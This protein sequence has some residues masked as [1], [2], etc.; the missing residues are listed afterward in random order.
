MVL[1]TQV[2]SEG[3]NT[4]IKQCK[5]ILFEKNNLII[6]F[7]NLNKSG[8]Y[9]ISASLTSDEDYMTSFFCIDKTKDNSKSY[10]CMG[11]DDAGRLWVKPYKRGFKVKFGNIRLDTEYRD[12]N[13]EMIS[14]EIPS[15]TS[16]YIYG[17]CI[18]KT[19]WINTKYTDG[20]E[21]T[22]EYFDSGK[23]NQ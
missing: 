13:D 2:F 1:S 4:S 3:K 15:E 14:K 8:N 20:I 16:D 5:Y 9:L 23:L 10:T 6:N 21:D 19:G 12:D 22:K 18:P 11:D 7:T 17:K